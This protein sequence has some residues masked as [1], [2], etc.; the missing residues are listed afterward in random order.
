MTAAASMRPIARSE[1]AS[2]VTAAAEQSTSS[3][4]WRASHR[5]RMC[6]VGLGLLAKY[7]MCLNTHARTHVQSRLPTVNYHHLSYATGYTRDE[8]AYSVY[9]RHLFCG[10]SPP[11]KKTCN[12]PPCMTTARGQKVKG[13]DHQV[14]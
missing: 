6:S 14:T 9:S 7:A 12:F 8:L 11:P 5:S 2:S 13:Q 10:G 4:R 1:L 3:P